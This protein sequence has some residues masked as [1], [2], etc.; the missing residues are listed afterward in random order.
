MIRIIGIAA[1]ATCGPRTVSAASARTATLGVDAV[2]LDLHLTQD[3]EVVVIHDPL[4][5][6]TTNGRGAVSAPQPRRLCGR[7][8][9]NDT[10]DQTIPTLAQVLDI[11]APTRL[12]L[13][14]EMKTDARGLPY[15]G[16]IEKTAALVERAGADR[17][18]P[19]HLLRAGGDRGDARPSSTLSSSRLAR[20]PLGRDA[21]GSR[22]RDPAFHRRLTA[23]SPSSGRCSRP[24]SDAATSRSAPIGSASGSRTRL[25]S[26]IFGFGS[27]SGRSPP[28]AR[29]WH[30][31]FGRSSSAACG[32]PTLAIER[33][34]A[35]GRTGFDWGHPE[36]RLGQLQ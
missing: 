12:A 22:A 19:A 5:E 29:T 35:S 1:P 20:S 32:Q 18:L 3:G 9:L 15:P 21:R 31:Q 6:R 30:S 26:S 34:F 27:R 23:R 14:L 16:L 28:T 11:F 4:L 33:P 17:P 7:L 10:L 2:E 25:A 24:T 36:Q 13:E 8:R